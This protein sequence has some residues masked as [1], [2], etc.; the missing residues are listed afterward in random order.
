MKTLTIDWETYQE[1]LGA[2]GRRARAELLRRL[3]EAKKARDKG[4]E[5][6]AVTILAEEFEEDHL[7]LVRILDLFGLQKKAA[8]I[9]GTPIGQASAQEDNQ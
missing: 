2:A 7:G 1:E 3:F 4:D 9:F 8:E 5:R 6:E